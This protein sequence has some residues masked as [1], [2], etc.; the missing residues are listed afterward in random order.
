M[1]KLLNLQ[2]LSK[3]TQKKIRNAVGVIYG[4]Q[5]ITIKDLIK[6]AINDGVDIGKRKE[7]QI[8]RAYEYFGEIENARIEEENKAKTKKIKEKKII[9]IQLK[10]KCAKKNI[11]KFSMSIKVIE[12]NNDFNITYKASQNPINEIERINIKLKK[13][14]DKYINDLTNTTNAIINFNSKIESLDLL[15]KT[16]IGSSGIGA[17]YIE[18]YTFTMTDIKKPIPFMENVI[19]DAGAMELDG[20]IENN[21]W[22]KNRKMCV[23]DWLMY[24]Y[25]NTKGH[26]KSVKDDETIE[27]LATHKD[28]E[29]FLKNEPNKNGY[30]LYNV[31]LFCENT[32]KTLIV[33]HNGEI[34]IYNQIKKCED[35]LVIEVKNNHLYPITNKKKIQSLTM[36]GSSSFIQKHK[37]KEKEEIIYKNIEYITPSGNCYDFLLDTMKKLNTQ[38]YNKKITITNGNLHNFN[39]GDTLYATSPF[40]EEVQK[41]CESINIKYEGQNP[42]S[43]LPQFINKLP[44]SFM[45]INVKNALFLE[46]VKFRT[47]YG[48]TG[49]EMNENK[50]ILD[51]NKQYRFIM[52]NPNDD[53]MTF[54]FN[55][56]IININD[57]N[58]EFGL[59]FVETDDMTILHKNNWYSNNILQM[60]KENNI[61]FKVKSF[62]KGIRNNKNILKNIIDE[63][64][65]IFTKDITKT[66]INSISGMLGKTQYS[67]TTLEVDNDVNKVWELI[68]KN[69]NVNELFIREKDGLYL[70]G[71]ETNTDM[72]SNNL[73]MYIQILDWANMLLA[74]HILSLGGFNHLVYRKTDCFI[75]NDI[76]IKPNISD[77]MGAYKLESMP[78]YMPPMNSNRN[79]IYENNLFKWNN[80]DVKNSD[81]YEKVISHLATNSLMICSKA[82][83]GK[84]FVINKVDEIYKCKKLAFTNKAA[85]NIKGNTLHTFFGIDDNYKCD[86]S[87]IIKRLKG[88]DIIIIDEISMINKELWSLL[89]QIK[90]LTN[91]KFL[92]CG[93]FRQLP[94]IEDNTDYFNHQSVMYICDGLRCELEYF[95]KCR[96]DKVLYDFLENV[97]N[98]TQINFNKSN[99]SIEGSHICFTNKRRKEINK[100]KNT[101]GELI[102][103][104]GEE[105]KYNED[106]RI[107][108][109]VPLMTIT[110]NKKLGFIKNEIVTITKIN[111]KYI[112]F[113]DKFI[114][115]NDIH[116]Y[117]MLGYAM[118]IHKSQ[119]DTI[120]GIVNICEIDKIIINKRMLYTA[121]SRATTFNNVKF[122]N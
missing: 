59:Y 21:K 38:I 86:L 40:N 41:Y 71:K 60:A 55:T 117:F 3:P 57:F 14:Y 110:S 48:T 34:I 74:K 65:E 35:P 119:G 32:N 19:L 51:I 115:K 42:L 72:M 58:N 44:K 102:K 116:K 36:I 7:T 76:G 78:I 99:F 62:I 97:Y 109:G 67:K 15:I 2:T 111:D 100:L 120:E 107:N 54:D 1:V 10:F 56:E 103:Y 101:T 68:T 12:F 83:T 89:Y 8:K 61:Y 47:H 70:Y 33:L 81:D 75:M 13:A 85:N 5:N 39:I 30:N 77:E 37:E 66:L 69:K 28:N 27:Y 108:V 114:D 84:S 52:E 80:I 79:V 95:E 64:K 93:D 91:I 53:F 121:I 92:L 82:G 18:S 94:P 73:P 24:K 90:V 43:F 31:S 45:N 4:I 96:Y 112:Y 26:I 16:L 87:F 88:I 104:E 63:I 25:K 122:M 49:I 17:I 29:L 98:E 50:H 46:N 11:P 22:C 20:I 118:T 6:L 23:V 105:N 113:E 9:S 106:I